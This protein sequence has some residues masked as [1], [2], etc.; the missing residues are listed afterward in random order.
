MFLLDKGYKGTPGT[1][2]KEGEVTFFVED[3]KKIS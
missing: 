2:G 3:E 1:T